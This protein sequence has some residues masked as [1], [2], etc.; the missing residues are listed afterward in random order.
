MLGRFGILGVV[1]HNPTLR[2]LETAYLIFS[3]GEWATWVAVVV[4][5]F[6]RGGALEAGLVVL[7]ELAPSV[8][9]APAVSGLGDRFPRPRVLFGTYLGQAILMAATTIALAA[10]A[11]ALV[12][13]ALATLTATTVA[14]SRPI[15]A[16]LL[17]ELATSPDDLAATNVASGMA[18]ST[19]AL[20]GPLAAGLFVAFGG[21]TAVFGVAAAGNF[22][23]SLLVLLVVRSRASGSILSGGSK[24]LSTEPAGAGGRTRAALVSLV[25]GASA[26]RSDRRLASVVALASWRAF[27]V[28][29]LDILYAVLA[30]DLLR[31]GD[32]G[33]GL[34]GAL[35]GIGAIAGSAGALLLV[36]RE[37][38]GRALGAGSLLFGGSLAVIWVAPG[39]VAAA[40]LL[41]AAGAGAA[42]TAVGA[43]TLIQRLAGDD[44]MSRV[45]GVVEGLMRGSTAL[46]AVTVPLVIAL[47]GER[48]TFAIAGLSLP[49]A[50][51]VLGRAI[52]AAD[53]LD[54]ERAAE[55]RLLRRIPM[56]APLSAPVLERLAGDL[57]RVDRP[58]GSTLI[59]AGEL[60]DRFYV[61]AGGRLQ[62]EVHGHPVRTLE[63]GDSFGEIALIREVP[64][65]ATV[66]AI[67]A[68]RLL[69]IDREPFLEAL[70]GQP[71]SRSMAL[72]RTIELL[73][74][75]A[76]LAGGR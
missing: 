9:G 44:V 65:T 15:H 48:A 22:V 26:I 68:V 13:Y 8:I 31:F 14:F 5:A 23:G 2:R 20:I 35:G 63:S 45:F 28:G 42:V 1:F 61:V 75:D 59:R 64:R 52:I 12:V 72:D 17:P 76:G 69:A 10:S 50:F 55:L 21:P 33:V 40:V 43:Q 62:V 38:L 34:L 37:G 47:V 16:S 19:G 7:V 66:M 67:D 36:G 18:E 30:I 6:G 53:R 32:S 29:A 24:P 71:R 70:T 11:P 39:P 46:G 54:P 41:I 51:A 60:G 27:L 57:V 56:L 73:A 58:A 74:G 49:I 4:Y 25:G 3:C